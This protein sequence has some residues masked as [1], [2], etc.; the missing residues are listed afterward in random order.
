MNGVD[1][2]VNGNAE[3]GYILDDSTLL[4]IDLDG[5]LACWLAL[6]NQKIRLT[7]DER[8]VLANVI[9][10]ASAT[11]RP[12]PST[13]HYAAIVSH[14]AELGVV[15]PAA[16]KPRTLPR[17]WTA[18]EAVVHLRASLG[19][20]RDEDETG[21][22][23]DARMGMPAACRGHAGIQLPDRGG[24]ARRAS[25][26]LSRRRSSHEVSA[27]L[28]LADLAALLQ[29]SCDAVDD[30]EQE[31][32][33]HRAYPTAGGADEL[34]LLVIAVAVN[35]LNPG[36]YRYHPDASV[37][38]P[39]DGARAAEFADCNSARACDYLGLAADRAP[40]ALLI[41]VASWPRMLR[42]YRDVGMISAYCDAG[43]LL[44]T[45]Y[46]VAADLALPCT[47]VSSLSVIENAQML[48]VDP[49]RESEVACFALG[50]RPR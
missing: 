39:L 20:P 45:M 4:G 14:L 22:D 31:G 19:W 17:Y 2:M 7:T 28:A 30:P 12:P 21:E 44:Q 32:R 8:E 10:P 46:L 41:I 16:R 50:G 1:L 5:S 23:P 49:M 27:P 38:V 6:R 37:L 47:A 29:V 3:A 9:A 13:E 34:S 33:R 26:L 35:D 15:R 24:R 36:A 25:D 11:R 43:A 42:R 18:P 48:D 40:A